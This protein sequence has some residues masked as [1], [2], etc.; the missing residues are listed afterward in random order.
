MVNKLILGDNLEVMKT[1]ESETVDL[2]Y[3][4]PPFFSNRDYEVIWGDEGEVRSFLD[5]WAGG[6]EHYIAWL[7]ER[8]EQMHRIL[9]PTGSIFL[10]CDWHANAEIKVDILNKLFGRNNFRNEIIWSYKTTLKVSTHH[11]GR[12]H[13]IIFVYA[14]NTEFKMHPDQNDYPPSENTLKRWGKYADANGFVSNKHFAGSASTIINTEDETKG[15]NINHGV[16]R[17]VWEISH[18]AGN[19]PEKIGYPTQKPMELLERIIKMA[20]NEGDIILDPFVGGGTTVAV[21]D[22][23]KRRW[24]GIDQSVAAVK[25]TDLRLRRQ[26]DMFSQPYE[27]KL[28]KYDYNMLRNQDA[29]EF[30]TWIVQQF[31]GIPN[32]KQRSDLGLDGKASDGAPIQVKRADNVSRDVIDKFFAAVQR[33]DKTLFEKN[34]AAGKPVGYIIAF[35]FGKGAVAEAARLKNKEGII[36]DLKKVNDIVDYGT[37]PKV[38]I[39]SKELEDYKYLLEASAES[40]AGIEFY[41]WDFDHKPEEGF[42]ADVVI[43][44]D[45]KQVKQFEP[46]EHHIAVEAV[47]KEGLEGTGDLKFKI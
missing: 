34:K 8:V 44:R 21:A 23:L 25:V 46:G 19:N 4:D 11:L 1:M 47:D 39:T 32:T 15:F 7:K 31:G 43:D 26:H 29:F 14:K 9:K 13:D 3:L 10:H 17:D 30:E 16:P 24:I 36:I 38:S 41:S 18:L 2:I 28:R 33:S 37:G 6:I 35:S 45:G 27:L 22:K 12:D 20:S 5:R 42:K 40:D